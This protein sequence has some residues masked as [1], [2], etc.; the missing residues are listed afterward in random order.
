MANFR[1]IIDASGLPGAA[2]YYRQFPREPSPAG[3][4][5]IKPATIA[6]LPNLH[7]AAVLDQMAAVD[8]G[9]IVLLVCHGTSDGFLVPLSSKGGAFAQTG[10]LEVIFTTGPIDDEAAEIRKM[11]Q[12]SDD[13][14]KAK[15]A[16]WKEFFGRR[17]IVNIT[18]EFTLQEAETAY[19]GWL[20]NQAKGLGIAADTLL[21]LVKK[22]RAVQAKRLKRVEVRACHVGKT[23]ASMRVFKKFFGCEQFLAPK[24]TTFYLPPVFV[25]SV[26]AWPSIFHWD[27]AHP[28]RVREFRWTR[29]RQVLGRDTIKEF[30]KSGKERYFLTSHSA[31]VLRICKIIGFEFIAAGVAGRPLS[32]PLR[33]LDPEWKYVAGFV[34]EFILP[35]STYQRGP[36]R[37]AGFWEPDVDGLPWVLPNEP[38]YLKV[39]QSV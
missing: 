7:F 6:A 34:Q 31:F 37:A 15:L 10:A 23:P 29:G 22:M 21:A 3:E 17:K 27:P 35:S 19:K 12:K 25:D 20:A 8:A 26:S 1:V 14:K 9:G 36:F 30:I 2:P 39:I 24:A 5:A 18:G 32:R 28:Q 4:L 11:P 13:D 16:R 38:Q 33:G